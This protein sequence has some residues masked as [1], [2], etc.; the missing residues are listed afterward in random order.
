MHSLPCPAKLGKLS[1]VE[2]GL[3]VWLS[4]YFF[5]FPEETLS[6]LWTAQDHHFLSLVSLL[7]T[8][9]SSPLASSVE[10]SLLH[11]WL[12]VLAFISPICIALEEANGR[13]MSL[14]L[15]SHI[16]FSSVYKARAWESDNAE[17]LQSRP[18]K[19]QADVFLGWRKDCNFPVLPCLEMEQRY[20]CKSAWDCCGPQ[21]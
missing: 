17:L 19:K 16:Y 20:N 12:L 3:W 5:I 7:C 6:A 8:L 11:S 18:C 14:M 21:N 10:V 15:R 13:E 9:S 4:A 2:H 1:V